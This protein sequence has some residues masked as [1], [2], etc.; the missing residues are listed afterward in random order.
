MYFKRSFIIFYLWNSSLEKKAD[1][2]DS[3]VIIHS[4]EPILEDSHQWTSYSWNQWWFLWRTCT[5]DG[6]SLLIADTPTDVIVDE[7]LQEGIAPNIVSQP[8]IPLISSKEYIDHFLQGFVH[9]HT[10]SKGEVYF[11]R[12]RRKHKYDELELI[13]NCSRSFDLLVYKKKIMDLLFLRSKDD[14]IC[15]EFK[16]CSWVNP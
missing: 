13:R 16:N 1:E 2:K 6:L 10:N 4:E 14:M 11:C 12:E 5:H 7:V 8:P 15:M 3:L 9:R